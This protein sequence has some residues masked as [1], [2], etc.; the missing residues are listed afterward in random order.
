MLVDLAKIKG[1]PEDVVL[2]SYKTPTTKSTTDGIELAIRAVTAK[3]SDDQKRDIVAVNIGTTVRPLDPHF[4][5][6]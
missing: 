5:R 2:A 6:R 3:L 1:E 4:F